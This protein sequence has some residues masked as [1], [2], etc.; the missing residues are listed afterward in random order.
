MGLDMYLL[1]CEKHDNGRKKSWNWDDFEEVAYWRKAN[2]I[3]NW[4]VN[5]VQAG[6]DD[7]GTYEVTKD[8]LEELVAVCNEVLESCKLENGT[9]ANG[10]Y[11]DSSCNEFVTVLEDGQYIVDSSVAE[12]LLPTT[13]GFFFGG[14][15]Y[16]EYY[17]DKTEET[18]RMIESILKHTNFETEVIFYT[19]SW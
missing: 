2:H 10:R 15:N 11:L 7:C 6:Q 3:H 1:R 17:Y 14:T 18:A 9:V 4:F 19:S 12:R 16:D 8:K 13:S 5:N